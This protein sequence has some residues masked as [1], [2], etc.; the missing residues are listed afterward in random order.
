M[1]QQA[2]QEK[3]REEADERLAKAK[4]QDAQ[5]FQALSQ[6]M[7]LVTTAKDAVETVAIL[8]TTLN[9]DQ[10]VG[11]SKKKAMDNIEEAA[12]KAR[13]PSMKPRE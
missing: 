8:A 6:A 9:A 11:E 3:K 1:Q 7:E 12:K 10:E 4:R 2:E 5:A 13:M